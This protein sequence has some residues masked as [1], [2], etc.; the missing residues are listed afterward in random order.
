MTS[1]NRVV[2]VFA[3]ALVVLA[4]RPGNGLAQ[5]PGDA[6]PLVRATAQTHERGFER[7]IG[8]GRLG[9]RVQMRGAQG[10]HGREQG[11]RPDQETSAGKSA[12]QP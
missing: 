10:R 11:D 2:L 1:R 6:A 8:D 9:Q 5:E 3:A 4:G 7:R 12:T